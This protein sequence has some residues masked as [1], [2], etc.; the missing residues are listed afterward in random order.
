[1]KQAFG[2]VRRPWGVFYLKHKISGEQISLK[3]SNKAEAQRLLQARN[4]AESQP[5]FNV[6]LARV[7][8]NGADPKRALKCGYPERFAQQALG[9][10]SKAVHN[11]YAKHAEVTVPCL[12]DW[13]K[14]YR[15]GTIAAGT[16]MTGSQQVEVPGPKLLPV[17]FRST[18][19]AVAQT[20]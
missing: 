5:Q 6:A 13:E 16:P 11:A 15:T 14:S 1:M 20:N 4:E 12:D 19:A 2:L 8:M 9:H 17:D 3:T 18:P 7:Y 10:N